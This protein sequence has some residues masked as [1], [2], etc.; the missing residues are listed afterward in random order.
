MTKWIPIK[1]A[2]ADTLVRLGGWFP[3]RIYDLRSDSKPIWEAG[4]GMAY[5]ESGPCRK[6]VCDKYI[7]HWQPFDA[8]PPDEQE[9]ASDPVAGHHG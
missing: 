1:T 9:I 3:E 7:T 8:P 5:T 4:Y 2:P 6:R